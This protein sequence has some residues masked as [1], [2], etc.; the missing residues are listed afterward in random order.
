MQMQPLETPEAD[1]T[2]MA[3]EVMVRASCGSTAKATPDEHE[4]IQK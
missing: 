1:V 3:C 4:S 2:T